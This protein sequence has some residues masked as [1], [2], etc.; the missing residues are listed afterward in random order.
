VSTLVSEILRNVM[1][2]GTGR[3]ANRAIQVSLNDGDERLGVPVPTFGKTGTANQ[4]TNS[5]FAGFIPAPNEHTGRLELESGFVIASYVGY[6]DNRSMESDHIAIYGSSGA[7]PIWVDTA[8]AVVNTDQYKENF[9]PADLIF[10]PWSNPALEEGEFVSVPVSMVSG[11]PKTHGPDGDA[12]SA[13][14]AS[15]QSEIRVFTELE[16]RHPRIFKRHF[17]P[18]PPS[19]NKGSSGRK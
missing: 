11:L 1:E 7:L 14:S 16:N 18:A 5:S 2:F 8:N 17:E 9:Q 6:D 15:R 13:G 10:G 3:K 19:K 12:E 4:Y